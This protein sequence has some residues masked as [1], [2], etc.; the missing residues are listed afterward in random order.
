[1]LDYLQ[2]ND[3]DKTV[4]MIQIENE[5]GM[6]ESARDHSSLATKEYSKGIPDELAKK[7]KV[8]QGSAWNNLAEAKDYADEMFMAWNYATYVENMAKAARE[9]LP[10]TPFSFLKSDVLPILQ[11]DPPSQLRRN[12]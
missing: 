10:I 3:K 5:I 8:K 1:M 11:S 2:A 12:P 4:A 9:K 7:L 6:L